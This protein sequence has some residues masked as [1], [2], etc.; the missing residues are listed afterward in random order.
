MGAPRAI[1]EASDPRDAAEKV[2]RRPLATEGPPDRLRA[3]VYPEYD[4]ETS[5]TKFFYEPA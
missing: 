4:L 2:L 1:I 5:A 3:R